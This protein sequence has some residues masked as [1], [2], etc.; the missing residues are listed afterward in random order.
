MGRLIWKKINKDT[1]KMKK[2]EIVKKLET[3]L[4]KLFG[5]AA[6]KRPTSSSH[7][8]TPHLQRF[9]LPGLEFRLLPDG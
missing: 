9:M 3:M 2:I 8:D 5:S 6:K 7:F 1:I 4:K